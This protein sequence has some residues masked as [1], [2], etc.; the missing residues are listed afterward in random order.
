ML[1][2]RFRFKS[3]KK[4]PKIKLRLKNSEENGMNLVRLPHTEIFSNQRISVDGCEGVFEY[5]EDYMKLRLLKGSIIICGDNLTI[6]TYE[7]KTLSIAGRIS[8][9]E[10]CMSE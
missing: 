6:L 9:V 7:N 2:E 1:A 8:S 5:R 3:N 4:V 10:F